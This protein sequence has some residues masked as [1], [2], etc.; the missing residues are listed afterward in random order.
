MGSRAATASVAVPPTPVGGSGPP[1][2][3]PRYERD[4]AAAVLGG[5]RIDADAEAKTSSA[6][7][8][9]SVAGLF[10]LGFADYLLEDEADCRRARWLGIWLLGDPQSRSRCLGQ[11]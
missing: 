2:C 9:G 5:A 4:V 11:D 3:H 7:H 1:A 8:A 6:G 10:R